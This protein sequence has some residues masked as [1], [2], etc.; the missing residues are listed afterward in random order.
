MG[1][2]GN[3]NGKK[4]MRGECKQLNLY[5]TLK[6]SAGGEGKCPN[7]RVKPKKRGIKPVVRIKKQKATS[8]ITRRGEGGGCF[9]SILRKVKN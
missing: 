4:G 3:I 2:K 1:K 5:E 8:L 7:V 9:N 6:I